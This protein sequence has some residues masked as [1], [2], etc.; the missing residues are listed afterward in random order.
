MRIWGQV[1][2]NTEHP[3]P[4]RS[5]FKWSDPPFLPPG[6]PK[7]MITPLRWAYDRMNASPKFVAEL[8]KR[9]L[10]LI[11]STGEEVQAV[12][13]K[14]LK[15]TSPAVVARARKIFFGGATCCLTFFRDQAVYKAADFECAGIYA[16]INLGNIFVPAVLLSFDNRDV[17]IE[18][19]YGGVINRILLLAS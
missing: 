7:W 1:A 13:A 19:K 5:L 2:E 14:A 6:A 16:N 8:K 12:V 4:S 10:R 11:A 15:D 17:F 18:S 3:C 9:K